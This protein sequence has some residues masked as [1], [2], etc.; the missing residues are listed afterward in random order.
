[1]LFNKINLFKKLFMLLLKT[2]LKVRNYYYAILA[3][4]NNCLF[5]FKKGP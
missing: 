1:M 5:N 4:K 3:N 2:W